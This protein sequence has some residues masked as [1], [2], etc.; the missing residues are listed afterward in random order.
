M[1]KKIENIQNERMLGEILKK[2][3][4]ELGLTQKDVAKYC[5]LSSN[6]LS[7]IE[8]GHKSIRLGT[9]LRLSKMLGFTIQLE[10]EL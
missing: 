3:R 8:L 9:L 6:G 1:R 2:R 7:Q 10:M 5:R 4:K